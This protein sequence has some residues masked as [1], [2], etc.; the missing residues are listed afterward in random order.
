MSKTDE[1]SRL[2]AAYRKAIL[3]ME[4]DGNAWTAIAHESA[5]MDLASHLSEIMPD[6]IGLRG[7]AAIESI[8]VERARQVQKEGWTPDHDDAHDDE[9]LAFAAVCYAQP[10]SAEQNEPPPMHWPW[11]ES[12]W[13]PCPG[14]RR[15]ELV[16]AGALI[17]AEIDRLDRAEASDA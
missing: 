3:D 11:D 9:E 5:A 14:D 13:K 6:T 2:L 17:V 10:R 16:K 1:L 12:R 8:A 4:A 7:L 15:R